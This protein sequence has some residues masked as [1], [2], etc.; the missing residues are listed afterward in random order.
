MTPT[1]LRELREREDDEEALSDERREQLQRKLER[2]HLKLGTPEHREEIRRVKELLELAKRIKVDSKAQELRQFVRGVLD[3]APQEKLLI[4][5]EYT[6][7]LDYL[8]DEVLRDFGPIAQIYGS[9]DPE[10][11]QAE[12][13]TF[14]QP[15]VHLMLATDA[16]GE[17]LNL[18]F[19]HL[20]I[21]YEL[22][23]NPNRIE[24]R[25]GR[26]HR[27]GQEREVRVYN[28]QVVNTR[29][30]IILTRLLE[31]LKTIERQLGG[32]APN[33]LGLTT[34][35]VGINMNRLSDL[36]MNAIAE[37]TPP[38]VTADHLEQVMEQRL[39]MYDQIE[40]TLFMPLR[41][42][43]KGEA[44]R[45]IA[46]SHALTPSNAAIESFVRRY[47]DVHGG[48]TEN[49]RQK[50]VVRIRTPREL[51]D[52]TTVLDEYTRATFDKETAFRHKPKDVQFIAFGHPLLG[53]VI[54][55]CRDQSR[56]LHGIACVKRLP[57]TTL[58]TSGGVLCNYTVRYADAHDHPFFEELFP[59]FVSVDGEANLERGRA[60]VHEVGEE[61]PN[62]QAEERFA[63]LVTLIDELEHAAQQA[64]AGEAERGYQ[65]LQ[66]E[67]NRQADACLESLEKFREAKQQRLQL[68]ILDYQ[69]RLLFGEDMDIAIRRAQYELE[70]LDDECERRRR[71]IEERRHVQVHAPAL[72]NIA[73][74][75]T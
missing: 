25:I 22:P 46:R 61:V 73:L 41:H 32:Y 24:Q 75:L 15:D 36:I 69:Q 51:V 9:M 23:W 33:I 20:M 70:R 5:T 2:A 38:E 34:R 62:P 57:T 42:F 45:V 55:H 60:L 4:F 59:V 72:L 28:M 43:D 64:A 49:T 29:E 74:L 31:K 27:Y 21:N 67:I 71:Q 54:R 19:C 17:G 65:R 35:D 52:G 3:K 8:R 37:D 44:D 39:R 6:D 66:A 7:T 47:C 48:K 68:S 13:E 16:A 18:Q 56:G 12:E 40:S 63:E 26:L 11:R 10:E 14:Q 53:M 1:E 50:G 30:G 58:R